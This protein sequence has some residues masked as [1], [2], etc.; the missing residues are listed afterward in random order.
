MV[1]NMKVN[2]AISAHHIH[3]TRQDVDILFGKGYELHKR[4]DLSQKG[5]YASEEIVTIKTDKSELKL[6]VLGPLRDYTQAEISKTDAFKM[7]LNPPV[8]DSGDVKGSEVVTIIGPNGT[9]EN[10]ECCI[11]AIRHIHMSVEDSLKYGLKNGDKVSVKVDTIKGGIMDNVH[12]KVDKDFS[13]E[14]HIDTDDGN[15]FLLKDGDILEV[16]K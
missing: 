16:I 3:L 11:L 15:A 13:L 6:R 2:V 9:I 8:R 14:M 10:K 1:I 4:N 12:I 7:G 5:Q